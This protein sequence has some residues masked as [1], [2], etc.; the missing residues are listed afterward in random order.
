MASQHHLMADITSELNNILFT[1][2]LRVN[3]PINFPLDIQ[4][5]ANQITSKRAE[6]LDL[7]L[8]ICHFEQNLVNYF[9][10]NLL[11]TPYPPL[12]RDYFNAHIIVFLE[13]RKQKHINY[14]QNSEINK[15]TDILSNRAINNSFNTLIQSKFCFGNKNSTS[16]ENIA[17]Y[18]TTLHKLLLIQDYKTR[19]KLFE[20]TYLY[21]RKHVF[22]ADLKSKIM[23]PE[24]ES[25]LVEYYVPEMDRII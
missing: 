6:I 23:L 18:I 4:A 14:N 15:I 1:S 22:E 19:Q 11:A 20:E 17:K 13:E 24:Y 8:E 3:R 25:W 7:I 12:D 16:H 5:Q 21:W 2:A 9:L 10:D